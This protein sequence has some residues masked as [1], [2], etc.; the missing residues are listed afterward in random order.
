MTSGICD[1]S[2]YKNRMVVL[3]EWWSILLGGACYRKSYALVCVR[4]IACALC[5]SL[6]LAAP[7]LPAVIKESELSVAG[8][9]W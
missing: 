7:L 8:C 1:S 5:C 4:F 6:H 2:R 3:N 9:W